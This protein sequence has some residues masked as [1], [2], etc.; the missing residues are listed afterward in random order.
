[1]WLWYMMFG[2]HGVI[3]TAC[4]ALVPEHPFPAV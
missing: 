4:A 3:V 1:V 2:A